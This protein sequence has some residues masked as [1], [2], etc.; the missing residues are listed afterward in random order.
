MKDF[1]TWYADLISNYVWYEPAKMHHRPETFKNICHKVYMNYTASN[2]IIP[3]EESRRH[4]YNIIVGTPRDLPKVDWT[5]KAL[6]EAEQKTEAPPLTGE[7]RQARLRE[8]R[9][10]VESAEMMSSVP[11]MTAKQIIEE[12]NWRAV[13][14]TLEPRNVIERAMVLEEHLEKVVLARTK[15]FR[16][17]F[18]DAS[19]EEV[20]AYIKKFDVI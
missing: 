9:E 12:G 11:R 1:E 15:M 2:G 6:A 13:A 14:T 8:W 5:K 19:D 7:A 3:I 10:K 18:P 17:A 20:E 4:A 16:S